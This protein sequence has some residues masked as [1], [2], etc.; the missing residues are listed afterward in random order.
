MTRLF[1][2]HIRRRVKSLDGAWKFC[3]DPENCG[4][5]EQW[6]QGLPNGET[7]LVP[8]VWNSQNQYFTYLG[9]AWYEKKFYSD[10]GCL[11]FCFGAV[12]TEAEVWLDGKYIGS[13]YGGFSQFELIATNVEKGFHLLTVRVNNEFSE[14]SI[15]QPLVDW[16]YHGGIIRSV[17][18]ETLEG[19]CVLSN[20]LEY[21]LAE[22]LQSLTGKFVLE[23]YNSQKNVDCT[24][25]IIYVGE[26]KVYK[27]VIEVAE[28]SILEVV[29]PEFQIDHVRLWDVE[30]PNLYP[31]SI[32]TD[33]DDLQDR[34]GFRKIVVENQKL[35]LNNKEIEL[36]GV[37]R[38]EE[39]PECGFAFPPNLMK[40]DLD[41]ALDMGCNAIRGS[42]YPNS[43]EFVDLLDENGVL[44]W[45]EIE[46]WGGGFSE[47]VLKN[48]V[49]AKRGLDMH[50]EMVKNYYNHPSII[51][52]GMHN[53]V[54]SQ[55][56]TAYD[57][58]KL[59]YDFLKENGGNRLVV[60]ATNKPLE[61]I[62]FEFCDV[63]C[64]NLYYGWYWDG[65]TAWD[66]AL[67]EVLQKR[68]ELGFE[69]KPIIL[70]EFGG[71]AVFGAHD[72]EDMVGSEEYQAKL[73]E[74][75]LKTF[76]NCP[77]IVGSFIWQFCDSRTCRR[78]GL[79]RARGFNNK[80]IL[81]EY[82]KPKLAYY[83]AQRLYQ[84]FAN[85]TE[86]TSS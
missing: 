46:F 81:N 51:I 83:A 12:M 57:L 35:M 43:Q 82:R 31:I 65:I 28:N 33:T 48:P 42:H 67:E 59:Y 18:V 24:S 2:E 3:I 8:T 17:S 26:E 16:Y 58:S 86:N 20:R 23:L 78:A 49:V 11:R 50:K 36:R 75:C 5:Q 27:G 74:Y 61:D 4:K 63:M 25:V 55:T 52:W 69:D 66:A 29:T 40:R 53:E 71:D 14:I 19:I 1:E 79:D 7:V 47:E 9:T 34:V 6:F 76:H 72:H 77:A 45:S 54:L 10:G 62:C 68:K 41:L 80:G 85:E 32:L 15:P 64:M 37:N 30:A 56:Q 22:D 73:I 38:H 84:S 70:S 21:E 60:Y 39:H 13:H 44:F